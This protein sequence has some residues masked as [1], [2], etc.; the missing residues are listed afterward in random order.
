M[1]QDVFEIRIAVMT[2]G[3]PATSAQ[4]HFHVAG[5]WR[6]TADLQDRSAK[7]RPAFKIGEAGMKNTNTFSARRFQFA[8]PQPLMLPNGLD[9]PLRG[10]RLVA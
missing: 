8:P 2:V 7:I 4:I 5:T 9:E 6:A 1:E 10:K 3:T